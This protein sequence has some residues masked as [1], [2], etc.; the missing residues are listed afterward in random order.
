MKAKLLKKLRKRFNLRIGIDNA[1]YALDKKKGIFYQNDDFELFIWYI[2]D[3]IWLF[4]TAVRLTEKRDFKRNQRHIK[5][6]FNK[7]KL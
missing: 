2:S 3:V 5:N 1:Y 7:I 6:T 4:W